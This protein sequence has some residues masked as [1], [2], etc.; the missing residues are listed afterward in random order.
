MEPRPPRAAVRTAAA[1]AGAGLVLALAAGCSAGHRSPTPSPSATPRATSSTGLSAAAKV[2]VA[3]AYARMRAEDIKAM[4][5][6]LM[7]DSHIAQAATGQAYGAI[8]SEVGRDHLQGVRFSGAPT[9]TV[10]VTAV[11]LRQTPHRATVRECLDVTDWV[12]VN[13]ATGKPLQLPGQ[14]R[15]YTVLGGLTMR[16]TTWVVDGLTVERSQPC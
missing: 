16:G 14:A 12:P 2:Q 8:L 5:T 11:D 4:R 13:A 6:S 10:S 15:R 3:A 7:S 1:A 9:S